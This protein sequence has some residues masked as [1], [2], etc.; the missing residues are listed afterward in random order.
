MQF[1]QNGF[2]TSR[3]EIFRDVDFAAHL[4]SKTQSV[5]NQKVRLFLA[6]GPAQGEVNIELYRIHARESVRQ[7]P[8]LVENSTRI[9]VVGI[10]RRHEEHVGP[11]SHSLQLQIVSQL[12]W[13]HSDVGGGQLF[14][15]IAL[16]R[17][18]TTSQSEGMGEI[19]SFTNITKQ[20][21]DMERI[22]LRESAEH[23]SV[24]GIV[25]LEFLGKESKQLA[26]F[27]K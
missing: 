18:K 24:L 14:A 6:S 7:F 5:L 11:F 13:R 9:R 8:G 12:L 1:K 25:M 3:T 16:A 27:G 10:R 20:L 23:D 4:F 22:L 2:F 26:R 21:R 17:L 19:S 15:Y